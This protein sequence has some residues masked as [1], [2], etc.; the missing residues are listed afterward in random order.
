[1]SLTIHALQLAAKDEPSPL[2]PHLSELI[3]GL[4]SF[5]LLFL[6]LRAKVFPMFEKVYGERHEAIEGGLERAKKAEEEAEA[7][8]AQYREQL[9]EARHEASRLREDAR[10]QGA[11]IIVEMREQAQSEARRIT[12]L[13]HQQLEADKQQAINQLRTQVGS[14]AVELASRIIGEALQD[15]SRQRRVVD[16]FLEEI[17][18][19]SADS[20]DSAGAGASASGPGTPAGSGKSGGDKA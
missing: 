18:S 10:E 2:V 3:V 9:A 13:A 5:T 12:E 8:L 17:E 20:G 6:F 4:V 11:A 15:D 19:G 7:A 16:R 1:M 14:L